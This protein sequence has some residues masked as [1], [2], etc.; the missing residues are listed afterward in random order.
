VEKTVA[1]RLAGLKFL[2]SSLTGAVFFARHPAGTDE[3]EFLEFR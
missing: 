2:G 1:E 3:E